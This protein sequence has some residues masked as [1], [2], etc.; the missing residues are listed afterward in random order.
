[1]KYFPIGTVITLIGGN[2]SLMIYGRRQK[3]EN[4]GITWDYVACLYPEGNISDRETVFFQNDEIDNVLFEGY[5]CEAEMRMQDIINK[6]EEK[7]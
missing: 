5:T 7:G 4:T 2:R 6:S 3:Q 1:M